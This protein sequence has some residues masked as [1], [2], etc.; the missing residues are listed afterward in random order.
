MTK[1]KQ[2]KWFL[3]VAPLL[4]AGLFM[5]SKAKAQSDNFTQEFASPQYGAFE[6]K[7]GPYK[8]AV[9]ENPSLNGT[10]YHDTFH[11]D[12]MFLTSIEMDWQFYHP[13]GVSLGVGGSFGFMQSSAKSTIEGTG[14]E[15]VDYTVLNVMPFA[16][17]FV[18]RVDALADYL[19]I[20][21]VPYAK[22]GFNWYLWWI[23][24][25]GD[26]ATATWTDE[27]GTHSEEGHGATIG[28]QVSPGLALRLDSFDKKS[29]RTFD[30]EIGVNHS[31]I[32]VEMLWA[33]VDK[34][35]NDDYMNLSTN[36][37]ANG[38]IMAGLAL[39]F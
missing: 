30:N 36:T 3:L 15:S 39:E 26:T 10:P 19:N 21:L 37:F 12:T 6:L 17:L 8:P 35:G 20:P 14:A 7:F 22:I 1:E 2:M 28:W 4:T 27:N 5:S 34:F 16:A 13:P 24:G 31:Y 11:D 18:V 33:F 32:F 23:L 9:D 38:T 25:G 29:A